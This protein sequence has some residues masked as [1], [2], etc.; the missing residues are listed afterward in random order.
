MDI[1]ANLGLQETEAIQILQTKYGYGEEHVQEAR[2]Q[3]TWNPHP[4]RYLINGEIVSHEAFLEAVR[5]QDDCEFDM[6]QDPLGPEEAFLRQ[7]LSQ[8][9]AL[10]DFMQADDIVT[11]VEMTASIE[12]FVTDY[13]LH[14]PE[15]PW[16]KRMAIGNKTIEDQDRARKLKA[17]KD[18]ERI[19]KR[20][21]KFTRMISDYL[22]RNPK[23]K[24]STIAQSLLAQS[25]DKEKVCG[26]RKSSLQKK[27]GELRKNLEFSP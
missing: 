27:V 15:H 21:A 20:D 7:F 6:E 19:Q 3:P 23:A 11:V 13:V 25:K 10:R 18:R 2:E 14:N 5:R 26:L 17:E 16:G 12:R 24:N 4:I 9:Q 22:K 1:G 8:T